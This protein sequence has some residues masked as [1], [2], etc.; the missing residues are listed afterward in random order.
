MDRIDI[1]TTENQLRQEFIQGY[2]YPPKIADALVRTVTDH[3]RAN[4]GDLQHSGQVIY[5]AVAKEEPAGKPLK[6]C[7]LVTVKLTL[8]AKGDRKIL[9]EKG[10]IDLRRRKIVRMCH[11]ALDQGALLT[12]E[13]LAELLTTSARTVR[14]D[15]AALRKEGITVPTRGYYRDIG[16]GPS[17]K[18]VIVG[19]WLKGYEYSEIE[20]RTHHSPRNIQNYVENFKKVVYLKDEMEIEDIRQ[21]T[22]LSERLIKEYLELSEKYKD[23]KKL[24]TITIPGSQKNGGDTMNNNEQ[25]LLPLREK[26][27]KQI[28]S[29]KLRQ[30]YGLL[31]E[32]VIDLLSSDILSRHT[33]LIMDSE[34]LYPGQIVWLAVDVNDKYNFYI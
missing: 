12:Q 26:S 27:P 23:N 15:I 28:I 1:K 22:G 7:Q 21:V 19:M 32:K 11:E 4:Y 3:I 17:H 10:L 29:Q 13:D 2:G 30:D 6:E 24:S 16:R 34:T 18:A 25:Y 31:G 5:L 14:Y 20:L 8:S 9:K 33:E